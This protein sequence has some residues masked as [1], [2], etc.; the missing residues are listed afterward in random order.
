[1]DQ[2]PVV[3]LLLD[4]LPLDM[5]EHVALSSERDRSD[6]LVKGDPPKF[7]VLG[8]QTDRLCRRREAYKNRQ[9]ALVLLHSSS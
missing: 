2:Q 9:E 5:P 6:C 3:W 1:M 4:K 8:I 7:T